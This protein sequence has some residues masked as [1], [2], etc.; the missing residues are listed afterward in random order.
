MQDPTDPAV[1]ASTDQQRQYAVSLLQLPANVRNIIYNFVFFEPQGIHIDFSQSGWCES[2]RAVYALALTCKAVFR[3]CHGLP[4]W[5]NVVHFHAPVLENVESGLT[6]A[7]PLETWSAPQMMPSGCS[8]RGTASLDLSVNRA[9][10]R[11]KAQEFVALAVRSQH[12]REIANRLS[13]MIDQPR[14][15][16]HLRRIHAHLG[17]QVNNVY[18]E[19]FFH[20]WDE[21]GSSLRKLSAQAELRIF[22]DLRISRRLVVAYEFD[23]TGAEKT[24]VDLDRCVKLDGVLTLPELST[25]NALRLRLWNTF[26]AKVNGAVKPVC[27]LAEQERHAVSVSKACYERS[28][29]LMNRVAFEGTLQ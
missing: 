12:A 20:A 24:L 8:Q 3:E 7:G 16:S 18:V 1:D 10:L 2:L 17:S 9:A 21:V 23:V 19:R 25:I 6:T 14:R 15:M 4:C 13:R 5:L 29:E 28:E 22:F 11:Q 26:F 27:Y